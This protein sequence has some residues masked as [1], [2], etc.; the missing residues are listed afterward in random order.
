MWLYEDKEFTPDEDFLEFYQGFVYQITELD[1]GMKY[2][3]KK[4]FWKPKTRSTPRIVFMNAMDSP[5]AVPLAITPTTQSACSTKSL[6]DAPACCNAG[7][8]FGRV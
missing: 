3:G 8:R 6:F 4:F 2:I 7:G 5:N 1:T